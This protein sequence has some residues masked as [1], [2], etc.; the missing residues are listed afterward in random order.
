M[1]KSLAIILLN[2]KHQSDSQKCL[3]HLLK[4]HW[5]ST[6]KIYFVDNSSTETD[7]EKLKRKYP[8]LVYLPQKY[9][10]GFAKSINVGL[11]L[12]KKEGNNF[13]LIINPDVTVGSTFPRLLDNFQNKQVY[14]V[15][16]AIKHSQNGHSVY[17]LDGTVDWRTAK[18]SHSNVSKIKNKN[19]KSS[20]FV[21]FACVFI[22]RYC[23]NNVGY[24]DE[25]Y[26]MYLEDV[27]YCLTVNKNGGKIILDP[28][29]LVEHLT[30]SSFSKPTQKLPISFL[31]QIKFIHKW[32]PLLKRVWPIIYHSFLYFYL[33]LLWTYHY[34]KNRRQ[35]K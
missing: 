13:F 30:S 24:L 21:T 6:P 4:C 17:G 16:P 32:L 7:V 8:D 12:A 34:E 27:D 18:A 31:S 10:Y 5:P 26:F 14:L 23:L 3:D 9:N 11:K 35:P 15:A 25:R 2:Y 28:S 1:T 19:L 22:S 29:I 20:Q 33:Y